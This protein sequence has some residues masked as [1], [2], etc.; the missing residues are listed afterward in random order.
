MSGLTAS[1]TRRDV[2]FGAPST[3]TW[4]PIVVLRANTEVTVSGPTA[5]KLFSTLILTR[6]RNGVNSKGT[7]D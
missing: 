6:P 7:A 2:A 3:L 1:E 4:S 5:G